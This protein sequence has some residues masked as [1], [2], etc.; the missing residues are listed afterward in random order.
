MGV[1]GGAS[2]GSGAPDRSTASLVAAATGIAD[3]LAATADRSEAARQLDPDA[4]A[5]LQEAG[6][7]RML[8]P[9]RY[10]GSD[11]G[12]R[13]QVQVGAVVARADPAAG[14][15][16]MV[17]N[18]HSWLAA[19]WPQQCQDEIFGDGPDTRIPGTLAAQGKA[20]R[21]G[22]GWVLDGRWQFASGV[23]HGTWLLIG[24]RADEP[25]A[26]SDRG[27]HVMVPAGEVDLD[28]TWFTLG[29]RG[30]GSKDLVAREVFVPAH[31]AVPSRM[32]FDGSGPDH[33]RVPL[34]TG[35]STMLAGATLGMARGA[36][37]LFVERTRTRR[38][39]YTN[40]PTTEEPGVQ[41]RLAEALAEL[42]SARLLALQT[43]DEQD[44]AEL[45]LDDQGRA[46]LKWHAT[47]AVELCRRSVERVFAAAGAH[48]IYDESLLQR[49][50]RD[51]NTACH[52][53]IADVD[54]TAQMYGR[55]A[56]GLDPG[57][58]LL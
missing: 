2:D 39:A 9:A 18:A 20:R 16:L 54:Q 34:I 25:T 43:A 1:A 52:H 47:Y 6:L 13:A 33:P 35:L 17:C 45:P 48:A 55:V 40:R 42:A 10:G 41:H 44:R 58:P 27:I 56:L 21:V 14:W 28:D 23:D 38:S 31:R 57:S 8:A 15:V 7:W 46:R 30:T 29:L 22:G 12:V 50:Y 51:L 53:A 3:R 4:V 11:A 37:D 24:A 32:L 36:L 5:A 19:R 26:G 49:R